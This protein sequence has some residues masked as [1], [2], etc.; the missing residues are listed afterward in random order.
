MREIAKAP[1]IFVA[2]ENS[3][4][5]G[6]MKDYYFALIANQKTFQHYHTKPEE[7]VPSFEEE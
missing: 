5:T 3:A 2:E 7:I 6:E 4:T 1:T